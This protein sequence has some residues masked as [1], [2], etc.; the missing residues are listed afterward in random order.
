M[1]N[2]ILTI[3]IPFIETIKLRLAES[4]IA[5]RLARGAFWSVIG[6]IASRALTMGSSVIVARLLGKEGYGEIGMVQSTI[7][8]LGVFAGFGLGATATKYIAEFRTKDPTRAAHIA[9]LTIL[10]SLITSGLMAIMCLGMSG[11][12][13]EKTLNRVDL[14]PL[15]AAGALLLFVSIPGGVLL[16]ALA[17]FEAFK[18]RA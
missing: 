2:S 17:G 5:Y 4:P 13:A 9:N 6:G 3:R 16:A 7:G 11:W 1:K 14:S 15:L 8:M 10:I 18:E 12:L